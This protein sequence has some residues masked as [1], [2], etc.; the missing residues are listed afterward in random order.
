V[1][2]VRELVEDE[3]GS[4]ISFP[5]YGCLF[6][7]MEKDAKFYSFHPIPLISTLLSKPLQ[8]SK[9]FCVEIGRINHFL[10]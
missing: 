1:E 10:S 3:A 4:Y 2:A 8:P 9:L 5:F 6:L 7:I